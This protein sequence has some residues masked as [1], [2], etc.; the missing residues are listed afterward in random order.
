MRTLWQIDAMP[1]PVERSRRE[2]ERA[3]QVA[4]DDDRVWL[5]LADL[6]TRTGRFEEAEE[7]LMR[8]ERA[9][10]DDRAVWRARL[11]WAQA[12]ERPDEVVRAAHHLPVSL[13]SQA[14]VLELRA[15]MAALSGDRQAERT[16]LESKIGLEAADSAGIERLADLAA[17]D[18]QRE[19][20]AELRRRKAAIDA[21]RV[22]YRRSSAPPT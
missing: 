10:P 19:Q 4:P 13:F 5:A 22:R 6:A 17:Q 14:R 1:Y 2:L 18:G 16:A 21:A 15:W 7:W 20:L 3:R 9:R 8:C 11:D 12:A